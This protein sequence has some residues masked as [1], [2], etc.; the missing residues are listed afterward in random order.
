MTTVKKFIS[1]IL[2]F[3]GYFANAQNAQTDPAANAILDRFSER[4]LNAPSISLKFTLIADDAIERRSDTLAG[5]VIIS[6][7]SY[8]LEI[9][10]NIIWFDGTTSWSYLIA[11]REVV[12]STPSK[13][14]NSFIN[15]PSEVFTMHKNGYRARLIEETSASWL[16]HLYPEDI[17]NE[18]IRVGLTIGKSQND[19]RRIEYR[20]KV[21]FVIY[22][23]VNE[24]NLNVRPEQNL[25]VFDR[26]A[27]R[28][29]DVIDMR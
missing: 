17:N 8:K 18:L 7:D 24:Y 9:P 25:F 20:T 15:K 3:A 16:I 4:A 13:N 29:V 12:I 10:N 21:G 1:L 27:H 19:L 22:I 6:K 23:T 5:S 14:D 2:L 26:A 11:E 28:G